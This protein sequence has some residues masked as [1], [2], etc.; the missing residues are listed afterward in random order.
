MAQQTKHFEGIVIRVVPVGEADQVVTIVSPSGGKLALIAKQSRKSRKRFGAAFDLFDTGRFEAN[1]GKTSLPILTSFIPAAGFN[2]LR[3]DLD[4]ITL[5]TLLCDVSDAVLHDDID[6]DLPA[7]A[8]IRN[9]LSSIESAPQLRDAFREV[10]IAIRT[11][12]SES[13]FIDPARFDPP[14][15]HRLRALI[16]VAEQVADRSIRSKELVLPMIER[17]TVAPPT[18]RAA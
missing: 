13:G 10:F 5:G 6:D 8:T 2:K 9:A 12:L 15:A 11:L 14:S 16:H 7:F 17:L 18:D 4:K 1:E 3:S